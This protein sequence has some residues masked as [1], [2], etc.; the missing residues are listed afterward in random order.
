[1]VL[2]WSYLPTAED[3]VFSIE[4]KK[5]EWWYDHKEQ[6]PHW[7][8]AVKQVLLVQKSAAAAERVFSAICKSSF[9]EQQECMCPSLLIAS[10]CN[11]AVQQAMNALNMS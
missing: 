5:V 8:S 6:L 4:E 3:V 2:K 9:N 1:M 10:K 11:V 7:A